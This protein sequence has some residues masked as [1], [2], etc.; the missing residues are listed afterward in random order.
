MELL[1][2]IKS[3][4]RGRA[5]VAQQAHNL[6]VVGSTPTPATNHGA[7]VYRLGHLVFNQVSRVRL[8]AALLTFWEHSLMDEYRL[9]TPEI[10]DRD[11]LFP[12]TIGP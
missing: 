12:L 3:L 11:P 6:E 5:V 4:S 7:V 8:S 10:R 9:V 1:K 2:T